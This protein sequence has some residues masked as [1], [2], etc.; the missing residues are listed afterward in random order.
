MI[1]LA[2]IFMSA[3]L[4]HKTIAAFIIA[5]ML[6][7]SSVQAFV[8]EPKATALKMQ[9]PSFETASKDDP[10]RVQFRKWHGISAGFNLA[11]IGGGIALIVL[12]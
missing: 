9:I 7:I 11:V 5:V 10:F 8:I 3:S 1:A 4:K 12:L 6:V 2:A